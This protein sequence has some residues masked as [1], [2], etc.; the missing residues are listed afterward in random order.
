MLEMMTTTPHLRWRMPALTMRV[1]RNE[2]QNIQPSAPSQSWSDDSSRA[3]VPPPALFTRMSIWPNACSALLTS[4]LQPA[5]VETSAATGSTVPPSARISRVA[6]S[7]VSWVRP[8][9]TTRAPS[10]ASATADA[11]PSPRLEP[12]MTATLSRKPRSMRVRVRSRVGILWAGEGA[13][14]LGAQRR[15]KAV[16]D[17]SG[18]CAEALDA[19]QDRLQAFHGHPRPLA[20]WQ[21]LE[22]LD[23]RF[24]RQRQVGRQ[25]PNEV[26]QRQGAL[27]G[28]HA[29][30]G[31]QP[32]AVHVGDRRGRIA[33]LRVFEERG[34]D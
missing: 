2:G 34:I 9:S 19:L 23:R 21:L 4:S 6:S 22:L 14:P 12:V 13:Q 33:Q 28:Q 31:L 16:R 8:L 11:L 17:E 1:S 30:P 5:S 20:R 15:A 7:R 10:R 25:C 26:D 32:H 29:I 18:A 3:G 24:D 27:A